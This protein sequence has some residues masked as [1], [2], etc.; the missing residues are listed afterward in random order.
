M[1]EGSVDFDC[2]IE[3]DGS[4]SNCQW[5]AVDGGDE[6]AAAARSY[7]QAARYRPATRGGVAVQQANHAI[8]I[9]FRL[10]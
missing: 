5:V 3:A 9:E 1:H 8:H 6:F 4:T 10:D 2:A 7:V